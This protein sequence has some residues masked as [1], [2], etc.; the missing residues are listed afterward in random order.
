MSND[1]WK[2]IKDLVILEADVLKGEKKWSRL[3][4]LKIL[5]LPNCDDFMEGSW[6]QLLLLKDSW[7]VG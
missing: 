4:I 7:D 6:H 2:N 5:T 3:G 1:S